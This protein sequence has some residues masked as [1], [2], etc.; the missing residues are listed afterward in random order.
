MIDLRLEPRTYTKSNVMVKMVFLWITIETQILV[1]MGTQSLNVDC[2][3]VL[4]QCNFCYDMC[5]EESEKMFKIELL[6]N[7]TGYFNAGSQ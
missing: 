4:A 7:K 1:P 3:S 5:T 6:K 2:Q